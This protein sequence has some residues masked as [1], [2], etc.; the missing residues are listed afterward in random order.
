MFNLQT[1]PIFHKNTL[2]TSDLWKTQMSL[3]TGKTALFQL[4]V[5]SATYYPWKLVRGW[6]WHFFPR[7]L[8]QNRH[9]FL[10]IFYF[11]IFGVWSVVLRTLGLGSVWRSD[12]DC[13]GWPK[14][15]PNTEVEDYLKLVWGSPKPPRNRG[16]SSAEPNSPPVLFPPAFDASPRGV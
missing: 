11:Y 3:F 1:A 9:F 16:P 12:W 2:S 8:T 7:I 15:R 14:M 6:K 10:R 13:F 5:T 4:L